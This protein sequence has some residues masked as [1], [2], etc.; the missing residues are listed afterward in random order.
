MRFCDELRICDEVRFCG[1]TCG[2]GLG[3]Q[4]CL[5]DTHTRFV[6]NTFLNESVMVFSPMI[7]GKLIN[8]KP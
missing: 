5:T 4:L 8:G 1:A 3:G 6:L 7:N 2:C